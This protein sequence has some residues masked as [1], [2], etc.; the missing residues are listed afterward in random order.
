LPSVQGELA[1]SPEDVAQRFGGAVGVYLLD[2]PGI[3]F[4]ALT[5]KR[6]HLT[7]TLVGE[8]AGEATLDQ[9]IRHPVVERRLAGLANDITLLCQCRPRALEEPA[10]QPY[11]NRVVMI[12]D[13]AVSRLYKNGLYSALVTARA[14]AAT[15]IYHGVGQGDFARHYARVC[16]GIARDND[17]G[18][19]LFRFLEY[20]LKHHPRLAERWLSSMA[21]EQQRQPESPRGGSTLMWHLLSG[22]RPYGQLGREMMSPRL[23]WQLLRP[24]S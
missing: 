17:R 20:Q 11:A 19:L 12:G 3:R 16:A 14:A 8:T 18:R 23:H 4:A 1:I 15:A 7:A 2:L 9:F 21:R 5:P 22:D 24:R 13:T 10:R 6:R